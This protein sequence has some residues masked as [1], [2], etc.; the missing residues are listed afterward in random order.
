MIARDKKIVSRILKEERN[1]IE[2]KTEF[3]EHKEPVVIR[4]C[5]DTL[6]SGETETVIY[7]LEDIKV[8][9]FDVD[10]SK[11]VVL[12]PYPKYD[13]SPLS[14]RSDIKEHVNVTHWAVLEEGELEGWKTRFDLLGSYKKLE[15]NIDLENEKD[16]YRA[17]MYGAAFISKYGD[18]NDKKFSDILCDLQYCIDFGNVS[19]SKESESKE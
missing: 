18:K 14:T 9:Y 12:P 16:V 19:D 7:P 5:H 11:W 17:L 8:G 13:F 15:L 1:W 3:P 10:I 4:L 2:S 6:S